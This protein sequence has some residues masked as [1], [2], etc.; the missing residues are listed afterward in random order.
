MISQKINNSDNE[1]KEKVLIIKTGW[2]EILDKD[3]TSR[4]TSLG[5]VLRTTAILP[6]YK[7]KRVTWLTDE[8]AVPLLHKNPMI[9]RILPADYVT[10]QQLEYEYFDIV[11]NLE[12]IPGLCALTKKIDAWRKYG[13]RLDPE[14]GEIKA[15]ENS[16]NILS[17]SFTH[18]LKKQNT[19]TAQELLYESVGEKWNG[20]EYVLHVPDNKEVYDIALNT[21]AGQK[22]ACKSW[23]MKNWDILEEKLKQKYKITRQ[24]KQPKEVLEN[25]HTYIKWINSARLTVSNDSLGMH[26]AFALRK[27]TIGL[28]GP[29]SATEVYFYGRGKAITPDIKYICIPCFEPNC[30]KETPCI[31]TITPER[32]YA[33]IEELLK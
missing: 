30:D 7:D 27:K 19:K 26:I 2:S 18:E 9:E 13:Y 17:V 1:R 6:L 29:T 23:S 20:E 4:K 14:S 25:L 32:V 10:F 5:D 33:E 22:W 12:K 24:D 11:V 8:K 28:F 15:Y 16:L 21:R 3:T 31:E